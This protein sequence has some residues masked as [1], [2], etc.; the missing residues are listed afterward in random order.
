M[1]RLT[2][3]GSGEGIAA[4]VTLLVD[5]ARRGRLRGSTAVLVRRVDTSE[6]HPLDADLEPLSSAG[7]V[8]VVDLV[9]PGSATGTAWLPDHL[10]HL[11]G[12]DA[13]RLLVPEL[14]GTDVYVCGT[15]PWADAV[16]ADLRAAGLPREA[17]HVA[18]LG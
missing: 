4:L 11:V 16:V 6:P 1:A 9:G 17:L 10:G 13:V 15:G 3:I 14:A 8:Q 18:R 12:T 2:L 7:L 5:A